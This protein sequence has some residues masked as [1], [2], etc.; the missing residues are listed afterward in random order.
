MSVM[1]MRLPG[2]FGNA[3]S[4][5]NIVDHNSTVCISVVHW[6]QRLVSLLSSGIPYLELHGGIIVEGYCLS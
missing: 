5:G 3:Y 2:Q 4:L 1:I 6:R